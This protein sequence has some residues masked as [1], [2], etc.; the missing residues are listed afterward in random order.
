MT[1]DT[2]FKRIVKS[3]REER[4]ITESGDI[5]AR[6]RAPWAIIGAGHHV[7]LRSPNRRHDLALP[8]EL[9]RYDNILDAIGHTPLVKLNRVMGDCP[10]Q[11]YAKC[12][13]MNPG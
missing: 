8:G 7:G 3:F 6:A 5:S 13:F 11:V 9:M 1:M 4:P 10:A 2:I 12:D